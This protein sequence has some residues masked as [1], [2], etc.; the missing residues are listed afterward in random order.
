MDDF[1]EAGLRNGR[2]LD[3]SGFVDFIRGRHKYLA[4]HSP[5]KQ[6]KAIKPSNKDLPKDKRDGKSKPTKKPQDP[7]FRESAEWLDS[8][9]ASSDSQPSAAQMDFNPKPSLHG[10]TAADLAAV[11]GPLLDQKLASLDTNLTEVLEQVSS[12]T[13]RLQ[14]AEQRISTLEDDLEKAKQQIDCQDREITILS[15]IVDDLENR[16]RRN[17]LRMIGIPESINGSQQ[18]HYQRP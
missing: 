6:E 12:Q 7:P 9:S 17:N 3:S 5:S 14:E 16:S 11:L 15:E 4:N 1:W 18:S 8:P 2:I 10:S 13:N